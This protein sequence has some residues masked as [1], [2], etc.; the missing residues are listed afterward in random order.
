MA[1]NETYE[2]MMTSFQKVTSELEKESD[3]GCVVLASLGWT[4][5]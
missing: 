1:S 5:R 2:R 4:N 3:R